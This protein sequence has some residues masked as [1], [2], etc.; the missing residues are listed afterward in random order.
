[1]R[2]AAGK[3]QRSRRGDQQSG[4][5]QPAGGHQPIPE[6]WLRLLFPGAVLA[7]LV[8]VPVVLVP[9]GFVLVPPAAPVPTVPSGTAPVVSSDC[10]RFWPV[11]ALYS[12]AR[13]VWSSGTRRSCWTVFWPVP[14]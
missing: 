4:E 5:S 6:L 9:L 7:P 13:T 14:R 2:A 11:T 8:L 10:G 1:R 3:R 12:L